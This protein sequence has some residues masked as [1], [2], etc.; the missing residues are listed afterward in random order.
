MRLFRD[1]CVGNAPFVASGL[2]RIL[3]G[4]RQAIFQLT[5]GTLGSSESGEGMSVDS[6]GSPQPLVVTRPLV[7]TTALERQTDRAE[8]LLMIQR[9]DQAREWQYQMIRALR[10][11]MEVHDR[12]NQL[13][14]SLPTRATPSSQGDDMGTV[15]RLMLRAEDVPPLVTDEDEDGLTDRD[16]EG[17][18]DEGEDWEALLAH[19]KL[20]C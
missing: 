9:W 14:A 11:L 1:W 7:P 8:D 4:K 13:L 15:G 17:S 6:V 20:W 19:H 10:L 18:M 16:A 3:I 5:Q 2:G 12:S